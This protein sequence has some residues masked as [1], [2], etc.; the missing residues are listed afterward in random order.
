MANP[1]KQNKKPNILWLFN[2]GPGQE[3]FKHVGKAIENSGGTP[4]AF[5]YASFYDLTRHDVKIT[6]EHFLPRMS[7]DEIA[8]AIVNPGGV[9]HRETIAKIRQ[10]SDKDLKKILE[11]FLDKKN[12]HGIFLPG[13]YFNYDIEPFHPEPKERP[14]Y[15]NIL[16][17][18]AKKRQM[19]IMGVC[20]GLQTIAHYEHIGIKRVHEM[21]SDEQA[22]THSVSESPNIIQDTI[23]RQ[24]VMPHTKLATE[25]S[26]MSKQLGLTDPKEQYIYV[27][28]AHRAA[29]DN[30]WEN[31]HLLEKKGYKINAVSSDGIIQGMEHKYHPIIGFQGH[32]EVMAARKEPIALRLMQSLLI[33]PAQKY[34]ANPK[35][36]SAESPVSL[37][38]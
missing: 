12:I 29:I 30:S 9:I 13:D 10:L 37:S 1:K 8:H 27:P 3:Y 35:K 38:R 33:E 20:G 23:R 5:N 17:E 19:P 34:M 26:K 18:I 31:R 15:S 36:L 22:R 7:E 24:L 2:E 21:V 28:E 6:K 14:R 16:I 4:I 25:M 11:D 32:P